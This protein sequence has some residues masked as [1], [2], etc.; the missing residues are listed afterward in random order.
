MNIFIHHKWYIRRAQSSVTSAS[1][2]PL[3]TNKFCSVLFSSSWSSTMFVINID[4]LMRGSV[5]GKLHGGSLQLF[6]LHQWSTDSLVRE[7]RF[8][9]TPPAF[10]GPIRVFPLEFCHNVWCGKSRMVWLP[11]VKKWRQVY[12]FWQNSRTWHTDT[13]HDGIGRA[14][15]AR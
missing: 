3:R 4:S 9:P 15:I 10:D 6:A 8:M 11:I 2:L 13:P 1:D 5:C 14:C 12:L 7:S